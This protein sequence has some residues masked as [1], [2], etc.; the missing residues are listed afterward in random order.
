MLNLLLLSGT[1]NRIWLILIAVQVGAGQGEPKELRK[2]VRNNK[3]L[4]PKDQRCRPEGGH[5]PDYTVTSR[6]DLENTGVLYREAQRPRGGENGE[7][8]A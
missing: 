3:K 4:L 2:P 8:Q 7:G 1:V 5:W 6:N